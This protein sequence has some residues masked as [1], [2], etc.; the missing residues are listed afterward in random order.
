MGIHIVDEQLIQRIELIA[1]RER[2]EELDV[3]AAAVGLYEEKTEAV[4]GCSFLLSVTNLGG[5]QEGDGSER[6]EE[7]LT[8]EIDAWLVPRR[9]IV[10]AVRYSTTASRISLS[11][12]QRPMS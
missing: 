8:K 3:I 12:L 7:I 9:S 11:C 5:S 6:N 1:R 4:G 2:H 10:N